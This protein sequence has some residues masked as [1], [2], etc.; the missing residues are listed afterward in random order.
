MLPDLSQEQKLNL[1]RCIFE[2]PTLKLAGARAG[3]EDPGIAEVNCASQDVLW[4]YSKSID[5]IQNLILIREEI[6]DQIE[7]HAYIPALDRLQ[8][9]T[10]NLDE[11]KERLHMIPKKDNSGFRQMSAEIRALLSA[12]RDE[13]KIILSDGVDPLDDP[14]L[15]AIQKMDLTDQLKRLGVVTETPQ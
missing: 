9:L 14:L 4:I 1:S 15:A 12:C 13:A 2:E 6:G 3:R 5:H 11:A 8:T 10:T 7:H